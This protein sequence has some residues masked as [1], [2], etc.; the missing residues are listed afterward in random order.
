VLTGNDLYE[1]DFNKPAGKQ[2]VD[3]TRDTNTTD[4][5]G[6]DVQGV[7][8]TSSDGSYIYFVAGGALAPGAEHR[9]C[10]E[11]H[12]EVEEKGENGEPISPEELERLVKEQKEEELGRL[13][14]GRGCNLYLE[15]IGEAPRFIAALAAKDDR[16]RRFITANHVSLGDWQREFGARTAEATPDG[17]QLVFQSTQH[18]T[19]YDSSSLFQLEGAAEDEVEVFVYDSTAGPSG[20]I[21][22]ASCDPRGAPPA[23]EGRAAREERE[24]GG[25][26]SEGGSFL[27][28]SISP[29][30]LRRWI[31]QDGSRV[32]FDSSQPLVPQDTNGIQDV[33]EWER[34]GT[35][36]CRVATSMYGGCVFLLSG[37]TS[38]DN[39]F[40]VD[41]D[42]SGD[43]VF[44]TH[45]GGLGGI[46][47]PDGKVNLFDARVDGGFPEPRLAC[48]GTGCQGVPPAAPTYAVPPSVTFTGAG[49]YPPPAL[50]PVPET[51]TQKLAKALRA[52]R[53][54]RS[55]KRRTSCEKG[56]RARYRIKTIKAKKARKASDRR[57]TGR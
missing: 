26:A 48:T 21:F 35:A 7:L 27:P 9:N 15:R 17:P 19:G 28:V 36:G 20:R 16:L 29:T 37:G 52:C 53:K 38:E 32:F 34:E 13:P 1:F 25:Q 55:K 33:Y 12:Q 6:A 43:N 54:D 30:S 2:L 23:V 8:A 10:A 31:S 39:S 47:V 56:A 46:A 41:A 42:Q 24:K 40:F 50:K 57:R 45:R 44:F 4:P 3:L 5:L 49:N 18:L 51:R 11:A 14:A 22:C